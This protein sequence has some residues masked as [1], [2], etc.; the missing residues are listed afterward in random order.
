MRAVPGDGRLRGRLRGLEGRRVPEPLR[1]HVDVD[2]V[3]VRRQG[4]V[5]A[6][7]AAGRVRR[8][9]DVHAPPVRQ[10]HV[11]VV[12]RLL[13]G[14]RHLV[15]EG[16]RRRPVLG[17]DALG[18]GFAVCGEHPRREDVAAQRVELGRGEHGCGA[19]A[20]RFRRR[21]GFRSG[22]FVGRRPHC[23]K[24]ADS[25]FLPQRSTARAACSAQSDSSDSRG[26]SATHRPQRTRRVAGAPPTQQRARPRR[27]AGDGREADAAADRLLALPPVPALRARQGRRRRPGPRGHGQDGVPPQLPQRGSPRVPAHR[28]HAPRRAPPAPPAFAAAARATAAAPRRDTSS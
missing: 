22:W 15:D 21:R 27:A 26:S 14:L 19:L 25:A 16:E 7:E 5:E 24:V 23:E 10:V 9:H 12:A 20:R 6:R 8:Q 13:R 3:D 2:G 17:H 1:R 11:R 28:V 18:Y 4:R